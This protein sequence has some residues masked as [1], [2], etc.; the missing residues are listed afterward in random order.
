MGN[1]LTANYACYGVVSS[2][3]FQKVP[4]DVFIRP[5]TVFFGTDNAL[6]FISL[7][8]WIGIVLAIYYSPMNTLNTLGSSQKELWAAFVSGTI[9]YW[10]FGVLFFY[11][12]RTS[13]CEYSYNVVSDALN[14]MLGREIP[15]GSFALYTNRR[16]TELSP[17][18]NTLLPMAY[19]P[20]GY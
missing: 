18:L 12:V 10:L 11:V 14:P 6:R 20:N 13:A 16:K 3:D 1:A 7:G 15:A 9:L 8:L 2:E 19:V 5:F 4:I 17:E